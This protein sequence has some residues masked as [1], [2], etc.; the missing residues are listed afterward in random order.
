[1]NNTIQTILIS[2]VVVSQTNE[3]PLYTAIGEIQNYKGETTPV[4]VQSRQ[5]MT[6]GQLVNVV[7]D[8]KQKRADKLFL[9]LDIWAKTVQVIDGEPEN[10][11]QANITGRLGSDPEI[12]WFES[13]KCLCTVSIA[14]KTSTVKDAKPDWF[15]LKIWGK[16]GENF[17]NIVRQGALISIEGELD[18][19]T[20]TDKSTGEIKSRPVVK[21]DRWDILSQVKVQD[22]Y[23]ETDNYELPERGS[24]PPAVTQVDV[25]MIPF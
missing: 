2:S 7:G 20:W 16:Q 6:P 17:K 19:E 8:I 13:G 10:L 11:N 15:T 23:S 18:V 25:D 14:V 5:K 9:G 3:K 21:V 4:S 12:K 1:M 22:S 24:L